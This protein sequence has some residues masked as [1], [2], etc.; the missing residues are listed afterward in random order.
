MSEDEQRQLY[1]AAID[2]FLAAEGCTEYRQYQTYPLHRPFAEQHFLYV[3][4]V[5]LILK[6]LIAA[7]GLKFKKNHEF[8]ELYKQ[9]SDEIKNSLQ[10]R[11]LQ[12]VLFKQYKSQYNHHTEFGLFS[13]RS[14]YPFGEDLQ[15]NLGSLWRDAFRYILQECEARFPEIRSGYHKSWGKIEIPE[16]LEFPFYTFGK[17][18]QP[19]LVDDRPTR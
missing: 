17:D 9:L 5:E 10:E 11:G 13:I 6:L 1:N 14:R 15:G 18:G 7:S 3:H 12:P 2:F 16:Q 8:C 4:S 19:V